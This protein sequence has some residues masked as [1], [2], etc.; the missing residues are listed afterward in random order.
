MTRVILIAPGREV[1]LGWWDVWDNNDVKK[2]N[3]VIENK[4]PEY[5]EI[6]RVVINMGMVRVLEP[7]DGIPVPLRPGR[8]L[9]I[10]AGGG[11]TK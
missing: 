6:V 4:L 7:A 8:G 5:G 11:G 1:V 2:I 9:S 10:P 3:A